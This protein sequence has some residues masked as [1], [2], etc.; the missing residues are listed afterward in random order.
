M[1]P[2]LRALA[3]CGCLIAPAGLFAQPT[4]NLQTSKSGESTIVVSG[5]SDEA[6]ALFGKQSADQ[7]KDYLQVF[8]KAALAQGDVPPVLGSIEIKEK[9]LVF[10]PRFPLQAGIE[11]QVRVR[12]SLQAEWFSQ[13]LIIAK[14][15]Q[16]PSTTVA[17]VYPTA[18]TLPQNL[19]KFYIYFSAP[20]S[21][22]EAYEHIELLGSDGKPVRLPFLEIAEEL[23]D[24][25][26]QRLTLLLDPGRVKRGLVP[27][28]RRWSRPYRRFAIPFGDQTNVVGCERLAASE[29]IY[30]GIHRRPGRFSPTRSGFLEDQTSQIENTRPANHHHA[31]TNGPCDLC[32]RCNAGE[33]EGTSRLR[34]VHFQSR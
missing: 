31:R 15:K 7:L 18:S 1:T 21:Q 22:G 10:E 6:L 32:A 16:K 19:L 14:K 12:E 11:Y 17:Q 28:R 27:A 13:S 26:G 30:E 23:W 34:R 20:M 8:V 2:L 5:C 24:R 25:D 3:I 9:S 4:I 33:R 29:R